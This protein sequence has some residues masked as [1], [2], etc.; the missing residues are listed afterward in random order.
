[1]LTLGGMLAVLRLMVQTDRVRMRMRVRMRVRMRMNRRVEDPR[2]RAASGQGWQGG[3]ADDP[4]RRRGRDRRRRRRHQGRRRG[5][6]RGRRWRRR[7]RRGR[8]RRWRRGRRRRL[9]A[10][11]VDLVVVLVV[12]VRGRVAARA[13]LAAAAQRKV[14]GTFC[15]HQQT[16]V[17]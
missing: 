12:G 14:Y 1:M 2:W 5:R 7:R 15:Q 6:G 8:R 4:R 13:R 17:D 10:Q 3:A 11:H 9:V 16:I